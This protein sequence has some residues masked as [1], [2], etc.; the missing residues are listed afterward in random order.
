VGLDNRLGR[1]S[2]CARRNA[3]G[4]GPARVAAMSIFLCLI[5]SAGWA[6]TLEIEI[7][8][9][10]DQLLENVRLFLSLADMEGREVLASSPEATD[11][12]SAIS[13]SEL[14]RLHRRAT[15]EI[16]EALSP[17]GHYRPTID[18]SLSKDTDRWLARYQIDPGPPTLLADVAISIVGEGKDTPL[19]QQALS[20]IELERGE[21]LVH[22]RFEA[23]KNTLYDTAYRAGY[24]SAEWTAREVRVHPNRERADVELVLD[25]GPRFYFGDVTFEQRILN[26]DLLRRFVRFKPGDPYD[27]KQL[28]DLQLMLS[29]SQYFGRVEVNPRRELAGDD[30]RI[31]ITVTTI[32][33]APQQYT[34]GVGFA[35]DTGPRLTFGAILRRINRAGHRIR[36]DLRLSSIENAIAARYEIPIENVAT[37]TLAFSATAQ[38]QTIGDAETDQLLLGVS[39]SD[40]WRGFRRQLSLDLRR[41]NFQFGDGPRRQADLLI[42]GVTLSRTRTDDVQYPREG[43]SLTVDLRGAAEGVL[44]DATF[45]RLDADARWV[46]GIAENA[47]VLLHGGFGA[48]DTSSFTTLPPS[49]R[50]FTGG[51]RSVRGYGYQEIGTQNADG[52][53]VGGEYLVL[54]S[55]ELEYLFY[56]NYGAA[57][58]VDAGDA[59]RNSPELK[60]GAGIGFRWRSPIGMVRLDLAHPFDDPDENF[61]IHIS[62][63]PDL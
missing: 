41:E 35:T 28:L 37:D 59:F 6:N 51:D 2:T 45:V 4:F 8:G 63:G 48:M 49:Q 24:L 12:E 50:F 47:R 15:E 7:V 55:A 34:V 40:G 36:A 39:R 33:D 61:R 62:I 26:R 10:E 38:Q 21:P 22:S 20:S 1:L 9:V 16:R 14:Q 58:F 3:A 54:G 18:A 31:P 43:Y 19:L 29:D 44:S 53:V 52:A 56:K 27:T 23:A 11:E 60:T 32:P 30:H 13:E 25:T 42:P 17:F 46:R 57:V 5:S